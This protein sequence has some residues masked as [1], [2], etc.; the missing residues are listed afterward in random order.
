MRWQ[1]S[2]II[3]QMSETISGICKLHFQGQNK[4]LNLLPS[5]SGIRNLHLESENG[6]TRLQKS[7]NNLDMKSPKWLILGQKFGV[8]TPPKI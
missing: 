2:V 3:S 7:D 8:G 1:K 4:N 5:V 6:G